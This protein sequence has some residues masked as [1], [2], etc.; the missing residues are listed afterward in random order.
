MLS[1]GN[2]YDDFIM[3]MN[4]GVFLEVVL[5]HISTLVTK[6]FRLYSDSEKNSLEMFQWAEITQP[7]A[8]SI[9][10]FTGGGTADSTVNG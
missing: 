5:S 2:I 7:H 6:D 9:N 8:H 10:N 4:W 3:I 1:L